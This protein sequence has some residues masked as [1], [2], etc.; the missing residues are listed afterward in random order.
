LQ[1]KKEVKT[2]INDF[3]FFFISLVFFV[4]NAVGKRKVILAYF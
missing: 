1:T 4:N 3:T 2:K